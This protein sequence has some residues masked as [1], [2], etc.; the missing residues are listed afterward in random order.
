MPNYISDGP[1]NHS[2]RETLRFSFCWLSRPSVIPGVAQSHK[3]DTASDTVKRPGY[4]PQGHVMAF[5][6][7]GPS[8]YANFLIFHPSK[9][10]VP[11]NG[12][13]SSTRHQVPS[14]G[15]DRVRLTG[16]ADL[17]S[18][19]PKRDLAWEYAVESCY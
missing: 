2:G 1:E 6:A 18:D 9:I 8:H 14:R 17:F 15:I 16:T 10:I 19:P 5:P 13:S 4:I 7:P 12:R 3:I 11:E